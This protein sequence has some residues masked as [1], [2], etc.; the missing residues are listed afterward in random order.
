[1]ATVAI[2]NVGVKAQTRRF[3]RDM[4]TVSKRVDKFAGRLKAVFAGAVT[5]ASIRRF[6]TAMSETINRVDSVAKAAS[7]LG[8]AVEEF[9]NLEFAAK[10]SGIEVRS[11]ST[12][13]QRMLRRVGAAQEGQSEFA[14]TFEA[15]NIE[16][17]A[18]A[19]LNATQKLQELATIF[20]KLERTRRIQFA[21]KLFD[22]EGV[23]F[24][25]LLDQGAE[26]IAKLTQEAER[27][28]ATVTGLDAIRLQGLRDSIT[29]MTARFAKFKRDVAG[30][31]ADTEAAFQPQPATRGTG[32]SIRDILGLEGIETFFKSVQRDIAKVGTVFPGLIGVESRNFLDNMTRVAQANAKA[33]RDLLNKTKIDE[34][35][36]AQEKAAVAQRTAFVQSLKTAFGL[37]QRSSSGVGGAINRIGDAIG[38]AV[39]M[40]DRAGQRQALRLGF[41]GFFRGRDDAARTPAMLGEAGG[42]AQRGTVAQAN[43]LARILAQQPTDPNEKRQLDELRKQTTLDEKLVD[44]IGGAAEIGIARL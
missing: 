16:V 7:R 29:N 37:Q 31:I 1:M 27:F 8:L 22:S 32:Q 42:A 25:N 44:I 19:R 24:L 3:N 20:G 9:S 36:L 15:L 11:F 5:L 34:K 4:N 41:P 38:R 2:L 6:Q 14:K 28:G 35:I 17:N 40:V 10:R 23:V 30:V 33:A 21:Q 18:F 39:D 26:G 43:A 13:L 12:G